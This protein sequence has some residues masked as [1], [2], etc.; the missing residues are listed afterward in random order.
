VDVQPQQV[1]ELTQADC[2]DAGDLHGF[3]PRNS[4]DEPANTRLKSLVRPA[5]LEPA[6][7]RL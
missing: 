6:T 3:S 5:G 1:R 7:K 4:G 2:L